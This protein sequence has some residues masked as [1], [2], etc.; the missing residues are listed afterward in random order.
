MCLSALWVFPSALESVG[1]ICP[2]PSS[3]S[4]SVC[5]PQIEE[6]LV[7]RVQ[8]YSLH[9]L[10]MPRLLY[11][12]KWLLEAM[13]TQLALS[14]ADSLLFS[15]LTWGRPNPCALLLRP[16]ANTSPA[17][18]NGMFSYQVLISRGSVCFLNSVGSSYTL[19]ADCFTFL[20][21]LW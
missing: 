19:P 6:A 15:L 12:A 21:N 11:Y 7:R 8:C 5:W 2:F 3:P 18:K 16:W 14:N 10:F 13:N 20:W 17:G 9:T 4:L 1:G